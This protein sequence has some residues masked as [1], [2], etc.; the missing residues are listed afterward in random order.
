MIIKKSIEMLGKEGKD[1]ITKQ[2]GIITSVCFD[3][4]GCIQVVLDEQ[5][6]DKDG[7][8]ICTGWIDIN[9]VEIT[10]DKKIMECP[11]FDNKYSS[12]KQVNGP[13]SKPIR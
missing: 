5:K 11:D 8:R 3:L 6:V 12:I 7:K 9:R 1:K 2:K 10:K 4:Y 13:S